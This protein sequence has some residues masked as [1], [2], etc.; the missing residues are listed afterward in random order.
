MKNLIV[1]GILLST[2]FY[3]QAQTKAITETG[4]EVIL[5][6]DGT[7]IYVN[8]MTIVNKEI[9]LNENQFSKHEKSSFLVKSK[10]VNIGIWINPKEWKFSKDS[11]NDD[12]EYNFE[13]KGGE[14]YGM[15]IAERL[16]IPLK[17]LKGY[18][19]RKC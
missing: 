9:I 2:A 17:T 1:V 10:K 6:N 8:E 7:W 11:G 13:K 16:Q 15:L 14:L 18:C 19:A 3:L 4:E 5:Y 12:A